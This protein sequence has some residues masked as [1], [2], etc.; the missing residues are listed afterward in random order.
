[1]DCRAQVSFF[2][3]NNFSDPDDA[4]LH[5]SPKDGWLNYLTDWLIWNI[6]IMAIAEYEITLTKNK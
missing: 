3:W 4:F 6:R 5:H 2:P 1:M